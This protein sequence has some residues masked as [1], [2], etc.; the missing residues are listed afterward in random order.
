MFVKL[1][2]GYFRKVL[3]ILDCTVIKPA[4]EIPGKIGNPRTATDL[5][6]GQPAQ[7]NGQARSDSGNDTVFM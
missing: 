3:I 2:I 5:T 7:Q 6:S 4:S 1:I